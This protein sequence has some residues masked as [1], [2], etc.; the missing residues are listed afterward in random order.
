MG[1]VQSASS[2]PQFFGRCLPV[3]SIVAASFALTALAC[4]PEPSAEQALALAEVE[5]LGGTIVRDLQRDGDPVVKVDLAD[6]PVSNADI[7]ALK[8]LT[9]LNHLVLR[10][11]PITDAGL[12]H[13]I[14]TGKL[15][16]LDLDRTPVTDTGLIRVGQLTS[17][18][19]LCLAETRITNVGLVHL[20][21]LGKLWMLRLARTKISDA[22]LVHL[23]GLTNLRVLDLQDTQVSAD[24][25]SR[26]RRDL[27]STQISFG[28][29]GYATR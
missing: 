5:R 18:R 8:G 10:N 23:R 11:T 14:V 22:G 21:P 1:R 24:G 20:R 26:L 29:R 12:Q 6:R 13:L 19:G 27:P 15:R 28:S 7:I 4:I 17:L 25:V 3:I 16:H 9:Q 2:N